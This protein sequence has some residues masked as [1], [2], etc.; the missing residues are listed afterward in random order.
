MLLTSSIFLS[1]QV[2]QKI[3]ILANYLIFNS[4]VGK[5]EISLE[6]WN[7]DESK[8]TWSNPEIPLEFV[9]PKEMTFFKPSNLSMKDKTGTG[10]IAGVIAS[11]S[12]DPNRYPCIRIFYLP[13]FVIETEFD[14]VREMRSY[15]DFLVNQGEIEEIKDLGDLE[16]KEKNLPGRFWSFYDVMRPRIAR[17][18]FY[19]YP[20]GNGARLILHI[21]ENEVKTSVHEESILAILLSLKSQ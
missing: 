16:F 1:F 19:L 6:N 14:M 7:F 4:R 2:I 3:E 12:K 17:T 9:L 5:E 15:L 21:T 8:S 18:G 13:S 10:Q 11:S 20:L